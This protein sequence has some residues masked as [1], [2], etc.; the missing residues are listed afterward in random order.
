MI[1]IES[2]SA[3][4]RRARSDLRFV[5][6]NGKVLLGLV[7]TRPSHADEGGAESVLVVA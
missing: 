5:L 7:M 4:V 6:A 2:N 3:T 1:L